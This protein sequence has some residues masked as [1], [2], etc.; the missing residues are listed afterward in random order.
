MVVVAM[1]ATVAIFAMFR[2]QRLHDVAI[3]TAS[4]LWHAL[5]RW[6]SEDL[7]TLGNQ[8][9]ALFGQVFL[10][11]LCENKS[12]RRDGFSFDVFINIYRKVCRRD[13]RDL[14]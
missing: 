2:S 12:M 10:R 14:E 4:Q 1:N 11:F 9:F 3:A 8:W 13:F 7:A 6:S 5:K